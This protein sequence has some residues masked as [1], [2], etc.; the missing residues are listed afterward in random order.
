MLFIFHFF[1]GLLSHFNHDCDLYEGG[2][3]Q[4]GQEG[5]IRVPAVVKWAGRLPAGSHVA[6]PTSQ[7]DLIVTLA[8]IVGGQLPLDQHFDGHDILPLLEGSSSVSPHEFLFHYCSMDI[9]A[10][11]YRPRQGV[12]YQ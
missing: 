6:E 1:E 7:M 12:S 11:R 3:G 2:K 5:A 4:G 10:V 9:H 8:G